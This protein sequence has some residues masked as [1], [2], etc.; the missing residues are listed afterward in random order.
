MLA[1]AVLYASKEMC[2]WQQAG[3]RHHP[4][5]CGGTSVSR[6]RIESRRQYWIHHGRVQLSPRIS[7][8]EQTISRLRS[9]V[10]VA[11]TM[12]YCIR[13]ETRGGRGSIQTAASARAFWG[14]ATPGSLPARRVRLVVVR[15]K[16]DVLMCKGPLEVQPAIR[17]ITHMRA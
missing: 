3:R 16:V 6:H 17:A 13:R 14:L 10:I 5:G 11:V 7:T 1:V 9:H 12:P 2:P 8:S 4:V 15:D